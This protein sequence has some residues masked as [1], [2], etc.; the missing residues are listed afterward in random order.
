MVEHLRVCCGFNSHADAIRVLEELGADVNIPNDN[1]A[2]P[3]YVAA[4]NGHIETIRVLK[5]LGAD[6]DTS[7]K[8]GETPT[9]IAAQM[10]I[11]MRFKC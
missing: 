10:A 8:D 4:Q 2:T 3:V 1:G 5:E 9:F 6:V 7:M 11:P